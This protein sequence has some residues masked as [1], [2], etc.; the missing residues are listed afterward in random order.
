[1]KATDI[2]SSEHR[3]IERVID[4]LEQSSVRLQKGEAVRPEFFIE[5]SDFIKG[6]AD[7]CHHKKEEGVL[8]KTMNSYGMPTDGS[9]IGVMLNEHEQ[10]RV[11]T[12][13]MR[14]AALRL[15]AGDARA[16]SDVVKNA[17]GYAALLRQ[18]ILKE[19]RIL[20]PMA[21]K[22]IPEAAQDQ[23]L[24]DFERVEHEETGAGVH[25]KYMALAEKLEKEAGAD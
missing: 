10:G 7:G 18:H 21:G 1:M 22:V 3:V 12:A 19:D 2:L 15:Q 20:F 25:E 17:Q 11:F 14:E 5:A 9:P 13:G 8:F 23:V 6:F 4:A 16:A 24:V